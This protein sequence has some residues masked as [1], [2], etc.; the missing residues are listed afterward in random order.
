M[1]LAVVLPSRGLIY[2]KT[3]EELYRELDSV[4][5]DWADSY[6]VFYSHGRPIP[7]CFEIPTTEALAWNPDYVLYVEED[8]ALPEGVLGRMLARNAHAVACDYPVSGSDN[9]TVQY[10]NDG[11]AFFTGC[12]LLLVKADL[13]KAMPKPIWRTD[14]GWTP[15][16]EAG[17]VYFHADQNNDK[18]YG[19]QDVAFGFRLYFNNLPIQVMDETIGQRK[20]I[21]RGEAGSNEG[22]HE[23]IDRMDVVE[24]TH[25]IGLKHDTFKEIVIDGKVVK[26][27]ADTL[28]KLDNPEL[29]D[30]L[31]AGCAVLTNPQDL[32][33]WIKID[34]VPQ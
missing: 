18:H 13:L 23:V 33:D 1:K 16:F 34:Y 2:S 24:R 9:G 19:Q 3:V 30:Y 8:M 7:D 32:K 21:K 25:L 12:G 22:F 26:L 10:D 6:R 27:K 11:A 17:K 28:A 15:H 4:T 31:Y 5:T 20:M 14:I 29:P